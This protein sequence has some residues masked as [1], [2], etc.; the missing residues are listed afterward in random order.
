MNLDSNY[1]S[2]SQIFRTKI[3]SQG[4]NSSPDL[5]Q[6]LLGRYRKSVP[7]NYYIMIFFLIN[8]YVFFVAIYQELIKVRL[9]RPLETLHNNLCA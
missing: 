6:N 3:L 1:L 5:N 4:T 8:K 9:M 2:L 7:S